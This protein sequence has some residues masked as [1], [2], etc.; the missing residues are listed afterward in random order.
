VAIVRVIVLL[1]L[2]EADLIEKAEKMRGRLLHQ[3]GC[4]WFGVGLRPS[5]SPASSSPLSASSVSGP[6][7]GL[8]VAVG[9]E[10]GRR[11]CKEAAIEKES[12]GPS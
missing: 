5:S 12:R 1:Y 4:R 3:R 11:R 7:V 8:A 2:Y 10:G 6:V 9:E